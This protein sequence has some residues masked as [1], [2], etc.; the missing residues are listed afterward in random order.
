MVGYVKYEKGYNL[1]DPSYQKTFI[2]RSLQIEE[3]IMQEIELAQGEC[4][5]PP[6]HDEVNDDTS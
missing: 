5:N 6:L 1:F 2:K 3:D 4:S